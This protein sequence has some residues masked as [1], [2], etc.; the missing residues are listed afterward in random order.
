MLKTIDLD[1][2]TKPPVYLKNDTLIKLNYYKKLFNVFSFINVGDKLAKNNEGYF[3]QQQGNLQRIKRWW[4]NESRSK[5]FNYLDKDFTK[6]FSFCTKINNN[7]TIPIIN[8]IQLKCE[9]I[10]LIN[11]IT[12]GLY[13]LKKTYENDKELEAEKLKCKIDSIIL[14]L[15]DFKKIC[16]NTDIYN[17]NVS[18]PINI[19]EYIKD[20]VY[21]EITSS[22]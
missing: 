13:N 16:T 7:I 11:I 20:K 5:T 8:G 19:Q 12:Q 17:E 10:D 2:N 14:T 1:K 3:I 22:L 4:H 18:N 15:I 6:F 9:L 21:N